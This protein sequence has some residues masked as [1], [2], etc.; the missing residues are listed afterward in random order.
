MYPIDQKNLPFELH[1]ATLVRVKKSK[2]VGVIFAD[3]FLEFRTVA[4]SMFKFAL[5]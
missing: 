4:A 3:W 1:L 5:V 2:G